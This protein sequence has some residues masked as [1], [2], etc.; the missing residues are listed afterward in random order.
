MKL[1]AVLAALALTVCSVEA[2]TRLPLTRRPIDQVVKGLRTQHKRISRTEPEIPV[3]DLQNL[4]YYAA[5]TIGT[6]AQSFEIILDTGSSNLWIPS[7]SCGQSCLPL[8]EYNSSASS[9]YVAN[10]T[11]F[12]I[13]YGSGAVSG[14]ISQDSINFGGLNIQNQQFAEVSSVAGMGQGFNEGG[15]AGILGLAFNQISVDGVVT[16]FSNIVAQGLVSEPVFAFYLSA[17]DGSDGEMTL[18]GV[19]QTHYTGELSYIPVL[20]D[21]YWVGAL[22]GISIKGT[23]YTSEPYMF[24]DTGTSLI[25]GPNADVAAIAAVVGATLIPGGGGFDQY[26]IDCSTIA[27]LP[28]ITFTVGGVEYAI[29]GE[30]YVLNQQ[31]QCTFG[32]FGA[33][34]PNN[35]WVLGDVF[36]RSVYCV[37][38]ASGTGRMGF[39]PIAPQPPM[40]KQKIMLE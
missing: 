4:E 22:D 20:S 2:L 15:V 12:S 7:I 29:S 40:K 33:A 5:V 34:T 27:S 32:L 18:G 25:G 19:D 16:V 10:G 9:T 23:N 24:V 37:F 3:V 13:Q 31:G 35:M 11:Q 17:T 1:L 30:D 36:M 8:P 14:I 38:D 39:A 21:S 26:S 6:P 28:P